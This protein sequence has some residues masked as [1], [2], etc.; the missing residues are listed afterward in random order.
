ME[1]KEATH[2]FLHKPGLLLVGLREE[3]DKKVHIHRDKV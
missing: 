3:V 1:E 2:I